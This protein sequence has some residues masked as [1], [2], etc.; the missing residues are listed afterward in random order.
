M[1]LSDALEITGTTAYEW[2]D[3][4]ADVPV[5]SEAAAQ[6]DISILRVTLPDATTP[7]P[8]TGV[9]LVRSEATSHTHTLHGGGCFYDPATRDGLELG[10]L[11]VPTGCEA[12]VSHQEHGALLIQ[13]GTYRLGGQRE[14]A[15]EWVRVAD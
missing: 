1:I 5:V 13:P 2:L 9:V 14:W 6:G 12:L 10:R 7:L 8:T 4:Q 11:T 3:R 15:G